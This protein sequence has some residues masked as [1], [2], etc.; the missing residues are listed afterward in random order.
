MRK[1]QGRRG[2]RV[3]I[4]GRPGGRVRV[5]IEA[6]LLD[7]SSTG[8]RIEHSNVLRPGFQCTLEFP[9]AL[10]PLVLPVQVIRSAVVGTEYTSGNERALRYE[11]G[12]MFVGL[13]QEQ[14]E[15]LDQVLARLLP[16]EDQ[17]GLGEG[18]IIL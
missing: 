11:S 17:A 2:R 16:P 3:T 15:A 18:R 9:A 14:R 10:G 5:T 8:A 4:A 13:S 7:L 1:L 12:V 6:R